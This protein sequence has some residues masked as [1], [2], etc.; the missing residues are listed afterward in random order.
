MGVWASECATRVDK[1]QNLRI[2]NVGE[3]LF[4]IH[5]FIYL[6]TYLLIYLLIINR[7]NAGSK[8]QR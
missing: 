3:I 8:A 1:T 4:E 5:L 7:K 6:F 2:H